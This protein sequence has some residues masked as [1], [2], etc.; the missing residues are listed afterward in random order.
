MAKPQP[1][2]DARLLEDRK[3][4][5]ARHG[6]RRSRP[7]LIA[8]FE[9]LEDA[10]SPPLYQGPAGRFEKT[11]WK[12]GDGSQDLGGGTMAVMRGRLFEKVGV[13]VS[14]VYGE[15]APEFAQHHSRRRQIRRPLLGERHFGDRAHALARACRRC[16]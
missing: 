9:A 10:A 15:F 8:R 11:A 2:D 4:T 3:V 7:T 6:S 1:V 16:T 14:C 13:H 12:R 5:G